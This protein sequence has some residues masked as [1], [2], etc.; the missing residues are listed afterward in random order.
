M[1]I[2]PTGSSDPF[3]L[4]RAATG[5]VQIAW[6]NHYALDVPQL[7]QGVIDLYQSHE[8]L[9]EPAATVQANL[10]KWFRQ[11]CE[12]LLQDQGLDYDLVDAVLGVDDLGYTSIN[13]SNLDTLQTRAQTL[14]QARRDATLGKV[15][16]PVNR[17]AR[18]ASQGNLPLDVVD[19]STVVEQATLTEAAEQNLYQ[20]V[21]D[22]PQ[23]CSYQTMMTALETLTPVLS[24]FFDDLLVMAEDL[25]VRQNRLNLLGV[26]RNYS[27]QLADFSVISR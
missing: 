3:A 19:V 11:R 24:K 10:I 14:Q 25:G 12:T 17:A 26:I 8:L 23:N 15:Y 21:L 4:R 5:V 1:G 9:T 20:A 2:I 13:L 18:L 16:E 6:E 7:L 27:R 22:L